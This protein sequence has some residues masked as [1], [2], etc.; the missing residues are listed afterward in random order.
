MSD[1]PYG[2]TLV[3]CPSRAWSGPPTRPYAAGRFPADTPV[4][5]HRSGIVSGLVYVRPFQ[6]APRPR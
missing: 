6:A 5:R 4:G 2:S 3:S 1:L